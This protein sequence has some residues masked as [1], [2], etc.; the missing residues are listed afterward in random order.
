M[1]DR[2]VDKILLKG[3]R[4]F[5]IGLLMLCVLGNCMIAYDSSRILGMLEAAVDVY[6]LTLLI[7]LLPKRVG[8]WI[9][10]AVLLFTYIV[11]ALDLGQ[12]V[13]T[14]QPINPTLLLMCMQTNESEAQEALAVYL[15]WK[16]WVFPCLCLSPIVAIQIYFYKKNIQVSL[17]RRY[18]K[19]ISAIVTVLLICSLHNLYA[20]KKYKYFRLVLQKSELETQRE[21]DLEPRTKF[22]L[23]AYRLWDSYVQLKRMKGIYSMLRSS[24]KISEEVQCSFESSEIILILGESFSRHHSALYGYEKN[25]TPYQLQWEKKGNLV[26]FTDAVSRWNTTCESIQSLLSLSFSG[27]THEWYER[28]FVTTLMKKAGYRVSLVSN[29]Y[30]MDG[31]GE[32]SAFIEDVFINI[33][34]VSKSQFDYRNKRMAELDDV[35]LEEYDSIRGLVGSEHAFTIFHTRGMHFDFNK[36]FPEDF[37]LFE[38]GDYD[39]Y[40]NLTDEQK[41]VIADYDNAIL[42]NDYIIN[43]VLQRVKGREAIV[44]FIPDHGERVY[45]FDGNF[46]RSLGFTYNEIVPQHEIPM[47][48]WASDKYKNSHPSVWNDVLSKCHRKYMTDAIAHT[49]IHLA[50]I[51]TSLYNSQADVLSN[52]YDS[53]RQRILRNELDY[54]DLVTS[55]RKP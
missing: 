49:I 24:Q 18:E 19:L 17:A 21:E 28:P 52:K 30:T 26:K 35:L 29:Q 44:F 55:A 16:S 12:V 34:E 48:V 37:G 53:L 50:G 2:F 10:I 45:D 3:Y 25:N 43:Q 6:L 54:D 20:E 36:R 39:G 8:R 33:P 14:G 41:G 38:A 47:W 32:K 46:G 31:A 11:T 4:Q 23:P 22:Y 42:Y 27:D 1:V 40:S 51:S 5:A 7:S 15:S 13:S 9:G